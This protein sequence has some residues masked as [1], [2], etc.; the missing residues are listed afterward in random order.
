[1]VKKKKN[2]H[3]LEP[4]TQNGGYSTESCD[5]MQANNAGGKCC[6]HVNKAVDISKVKKSLRNG[7]FLSEC[8]ECSK[9]PA[10]SIGI[11]AG[12]KAEIG[13]W[14]CLKCGHQACGRSR[15]QHALKHH[16]TPRSDPHTL[17]I[18]T[19]LWNIWCYDCGCEIAAQCRKKLHE[20]VEFVKRQEEAHESS[21]KSLTSN[22]ADC[23]VPPVEQIHP[24]QKDCCTQ[25]TLQEQDVGGAKNGDIASVETVMKASPTSPKSLKV[26]AV[27]DGSLRR[28][29]GLCN[30]GNTCFFNAVLQC[31]A[32]TPF[33]LSVLQ[34]M[35]HSGTKFQLPGRFSEE[36][37]L[38]VLEGELSK[39]GT[40]TEILAS[41]LIELQSPK[42]DVFN[43]THLLNKLIQ[44]CPQFGGGEQHDSHELLRHLLEGVRT[45]DLKR[46]QSAI[47]H[48]FGLSEKSDP[49]EVEDK[50]RAKAKAYGR[51][52]AELMLHPEQVFRGF[53][54][55]TLECQDCLHTS[56][57]VE[58]FLDLSLPVMADKP[59]PPVMRRKSNNDESF[60]VYGNA[61]EG[62]LSKHQLKKERRQA[63][64]E[65]K[66]QKG[67]CAEEEKPTT[68]KENAAKKNSNESEQSDADVEDNVEQDV[69]LK[70]HGIDLGE[71]G[72][73]SEK[74][75][76]EDSAVE[77]PLPCLANGDSA[78]AS[79]ASPADMDGSTSPV[80][81]GDVT[82][83]S[84]ELVVTIPASPLESVGSPLSPSPVSSEVNIDCSSSISTRAHGDCMSPDCNRPVS[85]FAFCNDDDMDSAEGVARISPVEDDSCG[86]KNPLVS[87]LCED[88]SRLCTSFVLV[89]EPNVND[90]EEK[91]R[92][93]GDVGGIVEEDNTGEGDMALKVQ[94]NGKTAS[95]VRSNG[96]L[97]KKMEPNGAVD[98]KVQSAGEVAN[99][100]STVLPRYKCDDGECSIQSCL[101]Q[102]TALE[103][104]TGNNKVG[105]ENCTQRQNQGKEGKMVCTNSTKQLLVKSPPAVLILHLKRFQVHRS[106]FRK[107]TR[108]VSFPLVLDL[109]PICSAM[110]KDSLMVKPGQNH[111]L[112]ALYGVVE[113]S[114]T[115]HGGHYV[116]YVKVRAPVQDTDPRWSFLPT[117][118]Q[119]PS[120]VVEEYGGSAKA[121]AGK[122]YF[123][124][125]SRV[126]E[127]GEERVL[128]SQ[129]YL[130]FYERFW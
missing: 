101:N 93:C 46:Y 107:L 52:A 18:N 50:V 62:P 8:S 44:R 95:E 111:V 15:G 20:C 128:R 61:S 64:K 63:R 25:M 12:D 29:R 34:E 5:E 19:E 82:E 87:D 41:T 33:L 71:S 76:N 105:C 17:V 66:R 6:P 92:V 49:T 10:M 99:W 112:Y 88:I 73:S 104:M 47:L 55:S 84:K 9:M 37:D 121:P 48:L 122:W 27:Q 35:S 119:V 113:H 129:A 106:M 109:A 124:S 51:Q 116:A 59:Q 13:L 1:M 110:Y 31:L 67:A 118:R 14:L 69:G 60:D 54:V 16:Q 40:L 80:E 125:D 78:L 96:D 68:A 103:L 36:G 43:P 127:V 4:S 123:V 3:Q 7:G 81:S 115:L 58:S 2:R 21:K 30:V 26:A 130:L 32:Q 57:R 117:E 77:S 11:P 65:R 79:P 126:S 114:G 70:R 72:Y 75:G 38:P 98:G 120:Q 86:A 28:V 94:L 74:V 90:C 22:P 39:W 85:R 42:R 23:E 102:F 100:S 97:A 45:E 91:Q 89:T 56:Q 53:L 108:H 83:I 24:V